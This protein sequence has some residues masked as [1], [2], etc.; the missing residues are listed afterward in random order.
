MAI[1][2]PRIQPIRSD[3]VPSAAASD[4][5]VVFRDVGK[6]Y[7]GHS[8]VIEDL[9]LS[10][11]RGEFL[12]VLGPS[13]SG[14][15]TCLM[16]L[17][18]FESPTRG[19]ITLD[20]RPI[21]HLPP[22]KREIGVVFQNN[23]LFPHMT[24]G[25]NLSFPLRVRSQSKREIAERVEWA[26]ELVR[27]PGFANRKPVQLSGGQQQRIA[28]A[29]AL[30][31]EPKLLLMD[32]PLGALDK[33]LREQMQ[34]EIKEL[35]RS[36]GLTVVYVTHD[37][38]E[39]MTMSDR[40]AVFYGGAIQQLASPEDLYENPANSFVAGF[41]GENNKL[42]G[43]LRA[44]TPDVCVVDVPGIGKIKAQPGPNLEVGCNVFVS[45][46]PERVRTSLTP[47]CVNRAAAIV[48]DV[49]YLGDHRRLVLKMDQQRDVVVKVANQGD[50]NRIRPGQTI[51]VGWAIEDCRALSEPNQG[52]A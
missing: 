9:N 42:M 30:I 51:D 20:G 16:L 33:Q 13:G 15:T 35:H 10:V 29:R 7:D 23:A 28:V 32:E 19:E 40:V 18:G 27:L 12:T 22:Y 4:D 17:A 41:I 1:N 21:H 39:A 38:S 48:H 36:L 3:A 26:L 37:Q 50:H 45:V 52:G 6:S 47:D 44:V 24:V 2:L 46:R 34:Y 8:L 5:V 49:L 14:K 43:T 11:R 25:Q 31:F